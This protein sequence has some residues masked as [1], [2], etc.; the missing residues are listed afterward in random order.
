MLWDVKAETPLPL[1]AALPEKTLYLYVY[2]DIVEPHLVGNV[3]ANLLRV[4]EV[5]LQHGRVVSL[6]FV[7]PMYFD[8]ASRTIRTVTVFIA[9]GSGREIPFERQA[10]QLTLH[11]IR[12]HAVQ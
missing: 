8:L 4:L 7:T 10:V 9:D 6:D 5:P 11:F 1:V 2:A 12:S 3:N